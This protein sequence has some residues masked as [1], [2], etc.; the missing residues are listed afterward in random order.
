MSN[1]LFGGKSQ[2]L[3]EEI[4]DYKNKSC[5]ISLN[6]KNITYDVIYDIY[7][8]L[9]RIIKKKKLI[10]KLNIYIECDDF[11]NSASIL[12]LEIVLARF[13]EKRSKMILMLKLILRNKNSITFSFFEESYLKKLFD[14]TINI[15]EFITNVLYNKR[16]NFLVD[17]SFRW[18]IN[19]NKEN[20]IDE[21]SI[22]ATEM[23]LFLKNENIDENLIDKIIEI[24][25]ELSS[26]ACEHTSSDCFV[27]CCIKDGM[28]K[29]NKEECTLAEIVVL[30]FSDIFLYSQLKNNFK[31]NSTYIHER[32]KQAYNYHKNF[33][34]STYDENCF[35]IVS[36]FQNGISTRKGNN[37]N[38][39]GT[40]LTRFI[41]TVQP[42][43]KDNACHVFTDKYLLMLDKK[44][45]NNNED[46]IGFNNSGRY[47]DDIPDHGFFNKQEFFINGTLY[48]ILLEMERRK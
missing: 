8:S 1:R 48:S 11:A 26:N 45:V 47:S 23:E 44:Y 27:F 34:G 33:F 31:D 10:K 35:F 24:T 20:T 32:I 30:N 29:Q 42:M 13:F 9:N 17:K 3:I 22:M 37:G 16:N 15:N 43:I 14:N 2:H 18:H 39:G 28:N 40:G 4:Y 21:V 12:F 19:I 46:E 6:V 38:T 7:S 5:K 25:S 36:A 41:K